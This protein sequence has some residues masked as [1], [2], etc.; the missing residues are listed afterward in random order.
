MDRLD[1]APERGCP[2]REFTQLSRSTHGWRVHSVG[3]FKGGDHD[4]MISVLT[5]GNSTMNYGV[6]TIQGVARAIH[7]NLVPTTG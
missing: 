7:K 3:T 2:V 5:H 6:T 1:D 4:Y